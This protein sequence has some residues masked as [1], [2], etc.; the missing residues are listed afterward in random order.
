MMKML[1]SEE[2]MNEY[3]EDVKRKEEKA[4]R[5]QEEEEIWNED[6]KKL[7]ENFGRIVEVK[8]VIIILIESYFLIICSKRKKSSRRSYRKIKNFSICEGFTRLRR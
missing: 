2:G 1:L 4:K 3:L 8:K 6:L 5:Q 7:Q